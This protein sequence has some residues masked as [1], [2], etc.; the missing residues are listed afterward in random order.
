MEKQ[1]RNSTVEAYKELLSIG[2]TPTNEITKLINLIIPMARGEMELEDF[3]EQF[4]QERE[5]YFFILEKIGDLERNLQFEIIN[6]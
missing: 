3:A 4:N 5:H 2:I 1:L 6:R